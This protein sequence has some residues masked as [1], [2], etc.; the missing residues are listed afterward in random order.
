MPNLAGPGAEARQTALLKRQRRAGTVLD[1][2]AAKGAAAKKARRRAT[3][4]PASVGGVAQPYY[5]RTSVPRL[6]ECVPE[7]FRLTAADDATTASALVQDYAVEMEATGGEQFATDW[8]QDLQ[9]ACSHDV[10]HAVLVTEVSRSAH[11]GIIAAFV[12]KRSVVIRIIHIVPRVRG[13]ARLGE[14][15]WR[16]IMPRLRKATE[17]KSDRQRLC[18]LNTTC[19]RGARAAAFWITRCGWQGSDLAAEAADRWH[20]ERDVQTAGKVRAGEYE[21]TYQL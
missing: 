13:N 9:R 14:H 1:G 16:E 7:Q 20:H 21:M 10:T 12:A 18:T 2:A 11:V 4:P 17:G 19:D 15:L 5:H 3:D 8:T 6:P